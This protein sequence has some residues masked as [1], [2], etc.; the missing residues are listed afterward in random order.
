M[1]IPRPPYTA[2]LFELEVLVSEGIQA[3]LQSLVQPSD[4]QA[5]VRKAEAELSHVHGELEKSRQEL[6]PMAGKPLLCAANKERYARD[7]YD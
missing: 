5:R 6:K 4:G 2:R 7:G 1:R 3:R